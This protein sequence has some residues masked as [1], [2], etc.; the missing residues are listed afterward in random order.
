MQEHFVKDING[1]SLE[2][3]YSTLLSLLDAAIICPP[4]W[5]VNCN[6]RHFGFKVPESGQSFTEQEARW[7]SAMRY[8]AD[9]VARLSAT[10]SSA[11]LHKT[12][13]KLN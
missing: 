12:R 6:K 10:P 4:F 11:W 13:R 3:F 7:S 2:Q 1:K 5:F 9:R 8:L